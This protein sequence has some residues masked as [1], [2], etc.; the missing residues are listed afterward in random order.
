MAW[1]GFETE[2]PVIGVVGLGYVGLP[3]ALQ[4]A[5]G[6]ARILGFDLDEEKIQSIHQGRSY[7][8]H[9]PSEHLH[10]ARSR[11]KLEATSDFS[12]VAER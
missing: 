11:D 2:S 9:I 1:I 8:R 10:E 7:I 3:L 5:K 4:F 12:R 6:N